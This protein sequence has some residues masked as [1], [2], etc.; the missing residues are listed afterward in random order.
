MRISELILLQKWSK[1]AFNAKDDA[2]ETPILVYNRKLDVLVLANSIIRSNVEEESSLPY[3]GDAM[4]D[5]EEETSSLENT[6]LAVTP[7]FTTSS[8]ELNDPPMALDS[9]QYVQNKV[10]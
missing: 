2:S 6:T 8:N 10:W 1:N 7:Q 5:L 3:P 9:I 4:M